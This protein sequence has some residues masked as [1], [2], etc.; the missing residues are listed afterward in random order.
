[1]PDEVA[2]NKSVKEMNQRRQCPLRHPQP[3]I[4]FRVQNETR[5]KWLRKHR[6]V[7]IDTAVKA[8]INHHQMSVT[9]HLDEEE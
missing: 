7:R 1:M 3:S 8:Q 9:H 4:S 6:H 2:V 5:R